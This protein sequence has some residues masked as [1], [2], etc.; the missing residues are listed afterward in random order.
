MTTDLRMRWL[1]LAPLGVV[2]ALAACSPEVHEIEAWMEQVRQD[3][4]PVSREID[5][6]KQFKAFRYD[7][8]EATGPFSPEKLAILGDP[9]QVRAKG[10]IAPDV[11]R[12]RELLEGFPLEQIA[13]VGSLR[14]RDVNQALLQ[15]EDTVYTARVGNYAGMN[16]GL[17][18]YI[19]ETEVRLLELV[20]DATGEWVQKEST[21][22]LQEAGQ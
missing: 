17:I 10:G 15:V 22:R 9:M 1:R 2:G 12:R 8:I 13:M 6:P 7:L 16:Y 20:Q 18:T 14:N 19:D 3:T 21:L 4:R 11:T 5:E